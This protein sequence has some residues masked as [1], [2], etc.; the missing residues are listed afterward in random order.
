MT[1]R[2]TQKK[3][4]K[5]KELGTVTVVET[6]GDVVAM[7]RFKKPAAKKVVKTAQDIIDEII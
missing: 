7:G 2:I 6:N 4:G 3:L 5:Y 1:R